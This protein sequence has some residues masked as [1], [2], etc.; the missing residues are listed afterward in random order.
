MIWAD[1]DIGNGTILF[2][3]CVWVCAKEE[4]ECIVA[5]PTPSRHITAFHPTIK[6][7][8]VCVCVCVRVYACVRVRVCVYV[9]AY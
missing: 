7:T 4:K 2:V 9:C 8:C 6:A 3:G 1:S 5:R